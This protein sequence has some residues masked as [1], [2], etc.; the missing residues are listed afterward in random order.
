M[1]NDT[2]EQAGKLAEYQDALNQNRDI[3]EYENEILLTGQ[4]AK[5]EEHE[6]RDT[7]VNNIASEC[8]LDILKYARKLVDRPSPEG[9]RKVL[10]PKEVQALYYSSVNY[11]M[12]QN[13][14]E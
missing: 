9:T 14:L 10:G 8:G 11:S 3:N 6:N 5:N 7:L 12:R 2:S 13:L 4:I 1:T